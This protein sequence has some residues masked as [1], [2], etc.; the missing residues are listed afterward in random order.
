MSVELHNNAMNMHIHDVPYKRE[1]LKHADVFCFSRREEN[2][3][4]IKHNEYIVHLLCGDA[5]ASLTR[6]YD[7]RTYLRLLKTKTVPGGG[8][9]TLGLIIQ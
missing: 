1:Y 8:H 7:G 3:D 2:V 5:Y 6:T 9:K 4:E